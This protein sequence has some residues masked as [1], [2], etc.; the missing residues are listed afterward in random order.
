MLTCR[1]AARLHSDR[2]EIHQ[3]V[4]APLTNA[5]TVREP[6]KELATPVGPVQSVPF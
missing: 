4:L 2:L 3:T 1:G 6:A 5:I